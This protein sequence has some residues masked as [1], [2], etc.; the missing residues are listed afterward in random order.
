MVGALAFAVEKVVLICCC[1]GISGI[2]KK[3]C[4]LLV[5]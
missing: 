3:C 5:P 4:F 2:S 1:T